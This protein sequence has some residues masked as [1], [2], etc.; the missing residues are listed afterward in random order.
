[1]LYSLQMP[2]LAYI[3]CQPSNPS[4]PAEAHVS[5]VPHVGVKMTVHY[6]QHLETFISARYEHFRKWCSAGQAVGLQG[7]LSNVVLPV[8]PKVICDASSFDL[9]LLSQSF[10]DSEE[11]C[12]VTMD[13]I[14]AA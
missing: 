11:L 9:H 5:W 4:P 14:W 13:Y 10:K 1:M 7:V 8:Q 2:Y 12:G 3:S 6:Q